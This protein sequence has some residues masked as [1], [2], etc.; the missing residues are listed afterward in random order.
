MMSFIRKCRF[1]LLLEK[2][3]LSSSFIRMSLI[4]QYRYYL[5]PKE[6]LP[7]QVC[8]HDDLDQEIQILSACLRRFVWACLS[9]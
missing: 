2:I 4:R 6:D 7:E 5:L 3:C 9:S 8:H 1:Y